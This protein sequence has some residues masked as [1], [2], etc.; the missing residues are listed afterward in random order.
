M[1]IQNNK[2]NAKSDMIEI[3]YF[4]SKEMRQQTEYIIVYKFK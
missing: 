4:I 2:Y 3:Y 1:R